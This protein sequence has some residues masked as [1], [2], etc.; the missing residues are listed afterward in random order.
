MQSTVSGPRRVRA[1]GLGFASPRPTAGKKKISVERAEMSI[2]EACENKAQSSPKVYI[3]WTE[4][5]HNPNG[6][7][8]DVHSLRPSCR[9]CTRIGNRRRCVENLRSG[10]DSIYTCPDSRHLAVG[11][12][13]L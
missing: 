9:T 3:F 7:G 6:N 10:V 11:S 8:S 1:R 5:L 13:S 2:R 12:Q 4:L